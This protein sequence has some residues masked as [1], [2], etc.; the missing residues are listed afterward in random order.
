M[1]IDFNSS[2]MR[3]DKGVKEIHAS[4]DAAVLNRAKRETR[5]RYVGA[6]SIGSGC[7]RRVQYEFMGCDHD[8][9]WAFDARTLRVFERGHKV[10]VWAADW[11]RNAGF[12]IK[13]EKP[14][15]RQF[16]FAV[17]N[18]EFRGHCDG[19]IQASPTNVT[20]QLPCIWE[21]KAIGPKSF[22]A[23]VNR[24]VASAKPEYADQ[25]ALYQSYLEFESPALF[26][27]TNMDTMEIYFELMPLD[28]KRAQAASDR[29]VAIIQDTHAGALRPRPTS[30]TDFWLCRNC[31][32][33]KRCWNVN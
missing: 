31:Q 25:V 24:G 11:L 27:A 3:R 26:Q 9:G 19:I 29:A 8:E 2:S 14:D 33:K 10:E 15:G 1:T 30:D 32:F 6:S 22:K 20:M 7:E 12:H 17:V 4:I 28:R 5:R 18:D 23:I 13:T 21:H 16:G